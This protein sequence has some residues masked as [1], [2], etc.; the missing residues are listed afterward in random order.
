[1]PAAALQNAFAPALSARLGSRLSAHLYE[2]LDDHG[3]CLPLLALLVLAAGSFACG[4]PEFESHWRQRE[5]QVD[6][7]LSDWVGW[8]V[9]LPR[10]DARLAVANDDSSLYLSLATSDPQLVRQLSR[11][12]LTVW[13][14]PAGGQAEVL[15]IR[16]PPAPPAFGRSGED[17]PSG[18]PARD[19]GGP[20]R[21]GSGAAEDGQEPPGGWALRGEPGAVELLGL[22]PGDRRRL[23]RAEAQ[24]RGIESAVAQEGSLVYEL[25]IPLA[26]KDGWN[27]GAGPGRRLG[28]GLATPERS[29]ERRSEG[30]SW[31]GGASGDG[32]GE[33][34]P[35]MDPDGSPVGL[36]SDPMGGGY[37]GGEGGAG[38]GGG[39]GGRGGGRGR[40]GAGGRGGA[41]PEALE[42]WAVLRLASPSTR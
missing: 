20:Q 21:R 24:A 13:F 10:V 29:G 39:F 23:T 40:R 42:V 18:R 17:W 32:A 38:L 14:D 36:G 22:E 8:Q 4:R 6:G 2:R 9:A 19:R 7:A 11:Q 33:A 25:R 35:P 41:R 34:G 5:I 37:G 27:L 30:R 1:M 31:G 3:A 12:G 16:L 15:G 26:A 28:V